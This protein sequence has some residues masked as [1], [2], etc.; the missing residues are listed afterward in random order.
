[1]TELVSLT[2][3][4]Q[5][6]E[7]PL[8]VT[9]DDD[10]LYARLEWAHALVLKRAKNYNPADPSDPTEKDAHVA[11]VDAW[12][13]DTAPAQVKAA[14]I[15]Q[16]EELSGLRGDEPGVST[17]EDRRHWALSPRAAG[18]MTLFNDPVVR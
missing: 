14:I 2:Q 1:M 6:V 4:K 16:F 10:D 11:A 3:A 15:A 12:T 7:R 9:L 13:S 8:D 5:A 18:F 17:Q